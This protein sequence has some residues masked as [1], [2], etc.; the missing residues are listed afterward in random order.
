MAD[1]I[2]NIRDFFCKRSKERA[3]S[4]IIGKFN[5]TND[6]IQTESFYSC[7]GYFK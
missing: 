5:G 4:I 7:V 2:Y 6:I 1:G 3:G